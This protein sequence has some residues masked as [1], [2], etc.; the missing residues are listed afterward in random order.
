MK[1]ALTFLI[2]G[3]CLTWSH[4]P[5]PKAAIPKV[6][7]PKTAIPKAAIPKTAIPKT[8]MSSNDNTAYLNSVWVRYSAGSLFRGSGIPWVRYSA[9]SRHKLCSGWL[10]LTLIPSFVS[11]SPV[12]PSLRTLEICGVNL[13]GISPQYRSS[14]V[15]Y[16]ESPPFRRFL[17]DNH[18]RMCNTSPSLLASFLDLVKQKSGVRVPLD[19]LRL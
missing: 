17:N 10:P 3:P 4:P 11:P 1:K 9:G 2:F 14:K 8:D 15:F 6:A 7:I 16:S 18:M 5:I 13:F 12:F 19:R